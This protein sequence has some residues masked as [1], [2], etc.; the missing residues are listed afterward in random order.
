MN[1]PSSSDARHELKLACNVKLLVL[2][3]FQL[4]LIHCGAISDQH[5]IMN[6]FEDGTLGSMK[7]NWSHPEHWTVVKSSE[8]RWDTTLYTSLCPCVIFL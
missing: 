1:G 2:L 8:N 3:F 4:L 6:T 5:T 7:L